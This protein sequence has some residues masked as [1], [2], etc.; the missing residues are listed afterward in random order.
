[1]KKKKKTKKSKTN[2]VD[3]KA[4]PIWWAEQDLARIGKY[5]D[6]INETEFLVWRAVDAIAELANQSNQDVNDTFK[7]LMKIFKESK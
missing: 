7:G 4:F 3:N 6:R 1:M 2:M 5:K